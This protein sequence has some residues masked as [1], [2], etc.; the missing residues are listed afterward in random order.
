MI[1]EDDTRG[2]LTREVHLVGHDQHGHAAIG[3][4]AHDGQD[5][6]DQLGVECA[7]DLVEQHGLRIHRERARDRDPLLLPARELLGIGVRLV[8]E[9]DL[10]QEL[11]RVVA[12]LVLRLA[13][14]VH[15]RLDDIADDGQVRE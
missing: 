14:D 11:V 4:V 7:G 1:H 3:E 6:C 2:D 12:R 9:P 13:Q 10:S 15:G 8:G 5:L